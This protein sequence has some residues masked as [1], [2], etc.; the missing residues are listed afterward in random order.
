MMPSCWSWTTTDLGSRS[1]P[2][3]VSGENPGRVCGN[4]MKHLERKGLFA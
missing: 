1:A 4:F 3:M 2:S